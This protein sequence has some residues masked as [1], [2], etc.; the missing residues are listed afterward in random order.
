MSLTSLNQHASIVVHRLG[1][2]REPVI[3]IDQAT[4][5][6]LALV[7]YACQQSFRLCAPG[8]YPGVFGPMPLGYVELVARK[9]DPLLRHHYELELKKLSNAECRFAIVTQH[10]RDLVP[11]Q[12]RPHFDTTYPFQF[13]IIHYLCR[14]NFG[15][16]SFYRH[17]SSGVE[18]VMAESVRRFEQ[19]RDS[20]P[21]PP[22]AYPQPDVEGYQTIGSVEAVFDRILIYRS[23]L[24]HSG[25][26]PNGM[27]FD[28]N[29]ARGRLTANIFLN[30]N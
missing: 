19:E 5:N 14:G 15:G 9:I 8:S 13:A 12:R 29:P 25:L 6:P 1:T 22:P 2:S 18:L 30:Y 4:T 11:A 7:S 10:P 26:I 27:R 3:V 20:D 16:T 28:S 17:N 23:C 21:L 24:L